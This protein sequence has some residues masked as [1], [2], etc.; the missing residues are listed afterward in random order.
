MIISWTQLLAGCP[1][2]G[3]VSRGNDFLRGDTL[4]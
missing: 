1:S 3:Q 2:R 4:S